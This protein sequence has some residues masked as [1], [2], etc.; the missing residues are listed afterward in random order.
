MKIA[1]PAPLVFLLLGLLLPALSACSESDN[2]FP[3]KT[4]TLVV[5]FPPGGSTYYTAK[6]VAEQLEKVL[7]Q[8]FVL[9]TVA[10]N[11]GFNAVEYMLEK[12]DGYRLMVGTIMTN[13]TSPVF[14][15]DAIDFDY[16][17]EVLP[18]SRLAD[19]P[20]VVMTRL[21]FPAETLEEFFAHL[22]NTSGKLTYGADFP[23]S[24]T[25][26]Y[27]IEFAK[28]GGLE[29]QYLAT[30]GANAIFANLEQGKV[31][32]A[33]MNVATAT[34]NAGKYKPLAVTSP[35]RLPNFPDVPTLA[36]IGIADLGINLW[37][38]MFAPR[39]TPN[40]VID[41]LHRALVQSMSS[42]EAVEA[43][44]MVNAVAVTSRSPEAFAAEIAA[45]MDMWK[46]LMPEIMAIPAVEGTSHD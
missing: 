42:P 8:P 46:E 38:G 16:D 22:R 21:S 43:F 32:I 35:Q 10:G 37:Q 45:E 5:P 30:S 20:H 3:V 28:A 4:V 11:F 23:G 12:P 31:D 44:E 41:I 9:E 1:R 39:G 14:H 40:E 25:D 36:E 19:F 29:V 13:S 15:G 17:K 27:L 24:A 6:V 33:V 2:D 18:V 7:G 34:R 26:P